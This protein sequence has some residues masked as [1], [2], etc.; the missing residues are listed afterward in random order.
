MRLGECG[1]TGRWAQRATTQVRLARWI[2][3]RVVRTARD[4]VAAA[5]AEGATPVATR[6]AEERVSTPPY[7]DAPHVGVEL[8]ASRSAAT[9]TATATDDAPHNGNHDEPFEG[10]DALAAAHVVQ[11]MPRLSVSELAAI[12]AY[13]VTH[14]ARRTIVAKI[15]Q[16]HDESPGP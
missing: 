6:V 2:G 12:R 5:W 7:G 10:Y 3:E 13:E 1:A 8:D 14:R 11:R 4:G 9:A 16:L 15:D